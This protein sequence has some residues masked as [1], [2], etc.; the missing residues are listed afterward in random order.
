VRPPSV[1]G[2]EY[3]SWRFHKQYT[4]R[5][6]TIEQWLCFLK[7]NHPDYR[8]VEI[9]SSRLTNLPKNSSILDQLP[10]INDLESDSS[11]LRA[12]L[13]PRSQAT[14][15][16]TGN[17]ARAINPQPVRLS[18]SISDGEFDDDVLDTLVPDLVPNLNELDLL[19]R[20]V[21]HQQ[22]LQVGLEVP[23]VRQ[24]PLSERSANYI[25]RGTF[26]TLFP[27]GRAD[28]DMP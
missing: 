15:A 24:T 7:I 26:P 21:H 22:C 1:E 25:M 23:T 12:H 10:H 5:R 11:N 20:E 3:L 18:N 8:D 13:P 4:A 28:F 14:L 27:Y 9:C 16:P 17:P 19:S 6:S 2:S